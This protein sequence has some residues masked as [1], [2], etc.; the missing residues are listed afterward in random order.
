MKKFLKLLDIIPKFSVTMKNFLLFVDYSPYY[1]QFQI[2]GL[3]PINFES[4]KIVK[5]PL[6][7]WEGKK[8]WKMTKVQ[9]TSFEN[10]YFQLSFH[11]GTSSD[12]KNTPNYTTQH[13]CKGQTVQ[14]ASYPSPYF[15]VIFQ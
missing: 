5:Y 10:F 1:S 6:T 12:N 13:S 15:F 7:S 3:V 9:S 14:K 8:E 11:F 4:S 2:H